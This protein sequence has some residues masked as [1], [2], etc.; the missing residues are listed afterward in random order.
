MYKKWGHT[1]L[2]EIIIVI[3]IT[4]IIILLGG[5]GNFDTPHFSEPHP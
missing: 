4:T 3:I 2:Y 5:G 1:I